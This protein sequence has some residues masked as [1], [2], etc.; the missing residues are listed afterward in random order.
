MKSKGEL[1]PQCPKCKQRTVHKSGKVGIKQRYI[2]KCGKRFVVG[3]NGKRG[4]QSKGAKP[5]TAY[6]R[7]KRYREKVKIEH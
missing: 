3:S 2:C 6:E 7:L 1:K 4:G 5:M